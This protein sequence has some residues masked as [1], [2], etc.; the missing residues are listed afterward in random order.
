MQHEISIWRTGYYDK[1]ILANFTGSQLKFSARQLREFLQIPVLDSVKVYDAKRKFLYKKAAE[2]IVNISFQFNYDI[3]GKFLNG[4]SCMFYS[5]K[6]PLAYINSSWFTYV[7][8]VVY[9]TDYDK[10]D[11]KEGEFLRTI[12]LNGLRRAHEELKID[13]ISITYHASF[14][15]TNDSYIH[16]YDD[17]PHL[18]DTSFVCP[19]IIKNKTYM[20]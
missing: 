5:V 18:T 20:P 3:P 6:L 4:D 12:I 14:D 17:I 8:T 13:T 16:P 9:L 1:A 7:P 10:I 19:C 2:D 15:L 11:Q